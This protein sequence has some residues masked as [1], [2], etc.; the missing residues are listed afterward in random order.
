MKR[1]KNNG[2]FPLYNNLEDQARFQNGCCQGVC[3]FGIKSPRNALPPF[4][5]PLGSGPKPFEITFRVFDACTDREVSVIEV[6]TSDILEVRCNE[7][8]NE[9]WVVYS[10]DAFLDIPIRCGYYYVC[11]ELQDDLI[12][13]APPKVCYTE[14]L[15]MSQ[16]ICGLESAGIEFGICSEVSCCDSLPEIPLR[17]FH[18]VTFNQQ[19]TTV[20]LTSTAEFNITQAG[21]INITRDWKSV[22]DQNGNAI[23]AN[24][25]NANNFL[26]IPMVPLVTISSLNVEVCITFDIDCGNGFV[27]VTLDVI[28]VIPEPFSSTYTEVT[29]VIFNCDSTPS[30]VI[31][32]TPDDV[33]QTGLA[34]NVFFEVDSNGA[35]TAIVPSNF[36]F[37][38][39]ITTIRRRIR[40]DCGD[41]EVTYLV[42]YDS[43]DPCGT[44]SIN[45]I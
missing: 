25:N 19:W 9:S 5:I 3:R 37:T 35:E 21:G 23:V 6:L 31:P 42:M 41:Y 29:P 10:G 30:V 26:A 43:D 16:T 20:V 12:D 4:Q 14:V 27:P 15:D 44:L 17:A 11:I 36:Q 33:I 28:M 18:R 1:Q 7:T 32:M 45:E 8:T 13:G 40:T 24:A 22:T 34:Q 38:N 39:E 2:I